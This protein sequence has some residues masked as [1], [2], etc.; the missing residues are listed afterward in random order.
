MS[1]LSS[2]PVFKWICM[3]D[4]EKSNCDSVEITDSFRFRTLRLISALDMILG[5]VGFLAPMPCPPLSPK[6]VPLPI[7]TGDR[8][9]LIATS[10]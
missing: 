7:I 4:P 1:S 10:E 6:I 2:S 8:I 9:E 5:N 3:Y